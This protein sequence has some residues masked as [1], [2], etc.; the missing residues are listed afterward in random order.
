MKCNIII[1]INIINLTPLSWT[2]V[3]QLAEA[4][5]YGL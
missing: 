4:R 2:H 5:D 3:W 1:V